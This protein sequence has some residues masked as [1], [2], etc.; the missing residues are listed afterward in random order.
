M[1]AP[2]MSAYWPCAKYRIIQTT[3]T[4]SHVFMS[5]SN[6]WMVQNMI[7]NE[8]INES[9]L[10]SM[11]YAYANAAEA[12]NE[13]VPVSFKV[14]KYVV[15]SDFQRNFLRC[16][17]ETALVCDLSFFSALLR[18][19][20]TKRG[21]LRRWGLR[22]APSK[23]AIKSGKTDWNSLKKCARNWRRITRDWTNWSMTRAWVS[24][25]TTTMTHRR[26]AV[27]VCRNSRRWRR[28]KAM[29]RPLCARYFSNNFQTIFNGNI[30]VLCATQ[31]QIAPEL[32]NHVRNKKEKFDSY[33]QMRNGRNS[34]AHKKRGNESK[35]QKTKNKIPFLCHWTG[36]ERA[37]DSQ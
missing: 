32:V 31:L 30:C 16:W 33:T 2:N 22:I 36:Q 37:H 23:A 10:E 25:T 29:F 11:K 7:G 26:V 27:F 13:T 8:F 15:I 35:K 19:W 24:W 20:A 6:A 5:Q 9:E 4:P 21:R 34:G 18:V 1:K 28:A 3:L 14:P 17:D 12:P